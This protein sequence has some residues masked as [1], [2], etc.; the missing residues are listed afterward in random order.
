MY[1]LLIMCPFFILLACAVRGVSPGAG[2]FLAS[3][4]VESGY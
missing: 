3:I 1:L 4:A 2:S